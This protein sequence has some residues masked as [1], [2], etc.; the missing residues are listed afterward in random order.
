VGF[1]P[2][3]SPEVPGGRERASTPYEL[4]IFMYS[5]F[6]IPDATTT[7]A[8]AYEQGNPFF[9]ALLPVVYV[10]IG[11]FFATFFAIFIYEFIVDSLDRIFHKDNE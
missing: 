3:L 4:L 8:A 6:T 9:Q 11:V 1:K 7:I 10:S 5:F 2:V